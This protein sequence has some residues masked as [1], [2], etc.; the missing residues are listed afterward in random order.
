[1]QVQECL[2]QVYIFD[3]DKDNKCHPEPGTELL[4]DPDVLVSFLN[5][6][7]LDR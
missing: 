2:Q 6:L 4:D 5:K 3:V 7:K 1:M